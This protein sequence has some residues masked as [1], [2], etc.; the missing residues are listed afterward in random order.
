MSDV[1]EKEKLLQ[2]KILNDPKKKSRAL[3]RGS[4]MA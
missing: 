2:K 1:V 4:G 3:G